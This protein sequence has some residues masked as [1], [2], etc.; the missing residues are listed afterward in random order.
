MECVVVQVTRLMVL[1]T[2]TSLNADV[3]ATKIHDRLSQHGLAGSATAD[4][5]PDKITFT[6]QT[7]R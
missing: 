6:W 3:T 1:S 2:R 7:R 4:R 5:L